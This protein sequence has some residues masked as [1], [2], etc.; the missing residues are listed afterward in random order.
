MGI[1]KKG[2]YNEMPISSFTYS[3]VNLTNN[4][5]TENIKFDKEEYLAVMEEA[6]EQGY[7]EGLEKGYN[8]G[9]KQ[10]T[11]KFEEE[12]QELYVLLE[13]DK[14]N[15]QSFLETESFNYINKF[16]KN[17]QSLILDSINKIFLNAIGND[18]ILKVYIENLISYF[19]E[20][21]EE[22]SI[23]I[24][25]KTL[26]NILNI[27]DNNKGSYK[28]DNLLND[29]DVLVFANNEYKEYFLQD[30]FNK[31]KELFN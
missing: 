15:L 23:V 19:N 25:E 7:K 1:L 3:N 4:D 16:Q 30:E 10:G 6:R 24:N 22:Y 8:D 11:E 5:N 21:F 18:E 2:S 12:K 31:I 14:E 28:I 13:S 20:T 9:Y 26:P 29:Y 17:M 27:I